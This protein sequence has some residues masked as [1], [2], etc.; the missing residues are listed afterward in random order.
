LLFLTVVAML[1]AGVVID[2]FAG[3]VEK[4][5]SH[6]LSECGRIVRRLADSSRSGAPSA[7]DIA[8]LKK[9]AEAIHADRL[10][11]AERHG[12][13]AE[14]SAT[15]GGTASDRQQAVSATLLKQL[16]DLLS[17]LDAIGVNVTPSD[18]EA[19]KQL[20]DTLVPHKSRPLLGALPYKHTNYPPREPA[21]S[22]VVKPAYKG[23]D[24]SV[25]AA[26]TATT[27]EAP[28][29]K[30]IVDLAQSLQWNP[31]LIYEWVKNN[32][33]TEWYWGSMKG[34][35]ETLR[36]KSGNDTDQ[37]ALLVALLRSANFPARYIKGTIEFFPDLDKAK[38]L[39]GLDDPTKIATF[40]Q[41]AG[42][43]FKP[44]IAGGKID[45]F[46]IEHIWVETY[47]SYSNSRG[48]ID[49]GM[50]KTWLGLDTSIKPPGYTRT[51][52]IA[53]PS[54]LIASFRDDYLASLQQLTPLDYIKQ[55]AGDYLTTNQ[56]GK[57]WSDLLDQQAII[58]NIL[59]IIPS[60]L[61]FPQIAITGEYQTL[62][63]E[64]K[65]KLTFSAT[66]GGNELFSITLETHKLSNKRLALRAEPE[67]VDDQNTIDSFGG[68]D[69]TPPYLVRLRPV[70]TVDGERMIV[71]QDGLPMGGD[72]TLSIDVITPNGTERITS[73]QINGNLSVI[74]VVAQLSTKSTNDTKIVADDDAETILHKEAI[75][76][77]GRWNKDEEDL[78]SL[79]GQRVS[80]PTVT[81]ATVGA[82]LEV[83]QL[84]DTPHDM[85]WKG[86]FLD[87]GYRRIETVGRNGNE[88]DFMRL[89]ALQGSILEN[90]IFEDDL[91]VDSVSTAKLLQLA[92]A[93]GTA[94]ISIDKTTIDAILP[95][96]TFDDAVKSDI[97]NAVNQGLAV[98]IPQTEVAYQNW[99]GI[100][101]IKEDPTTGES[102]W[103]LSGQVAGGMTAW[104][105]EQWDIATLKAISDAL[106]APFSGPPNRNPLDAAYLVKIPIT[107]QQ[108]GVVG[109]ILTSP[110]Q[111]KVTDRTGRQVESVPVTFRIKA[112]GGI[113]SNNVVG[114]TFSE[115]NTV[116]ATKTDMKGLA[117][118]PLILGQKTGGNPS[119]WYTD[120]NTYSNQYGTNIV[121]VALD[122][123]IAIDAPFSAYGAP[124]PLSLL[125]PT[126]G[127]TMQGFFLSYGGFVAL[128]AEDSYGNPIANQK[129]TFKLGQTNVTGS[130][131]TKTYDTTSAL[132]VKSGD[133]CLNTPLTISAAASCRNA[134]TTVI[135]TTSISGAW[136][137]VVLGGAPGATY[138]VTATAVVGNATFTAQYAPSTYDLVSCSENV[139][140]KAQLVISSLIPTDV[141]GNSINAA[142]S[143]SVISVIA[144]QYLIKEGD[145]TTA[146]NLSCDTG[147]L[148]CPKVVGNH[149]YGTTTD[150][151]D[152]SAKFDHLPANNLGNGLFQANYTLKPGLNTITI[153]GLASYGFKRRINSCANG[154][155][156]EATTEVRTL[157][158]ATAIQ[159]YGVDIAI[160]QPLNIMLNNQ[161]ISRNNLKISY[162]INPASYQAANALILLYKVTDQNGQKNYE[163]ID[164]ILVENKG[165]GF[166]TLARG[167]RFDDTQNY[168]IKVALNYGTYVQILSDPVPIN[169]GGA[170]VPDYNHNRK[171]DEEDLDRAANG[172]TYYFWV[173]DDDGNGDSEGSGIP[174]SGLGS[175]IDPAHLKIDGTRDL[176]DFFPVH[177]DL[178][179]MFKKY[180]PAT[181][182]YRLRNADSALNYVVTDLGPTESGEYLT[183]EKRGINF[184][185]TMGSAPTIS[186]T[187]T[188]FNI[189]T[190]QYLP[191]KPEVIEQI[192]QGKGVILIEGYKKTASS[193]V[194]EV[195]KGTTL[196]DSSLKLN[197]S[198]DGIEQMFRHKNLMHEMYFIQNPPEGYTPPAGILP[199]PNHPVPF[200]GKPDRL[201][202]ED[203]SNQNHFAGFDA[204]NDEKD[205]VHVHGYN[206][207]GQAARGEH[208]EVFKR[209]YWSGSN[210]K[211][212]GITWYGYDSQ[213]ALEYPCF[214]QRSPNYHVNVRHAFN[215]G[216]LLKNFVDSKL[217]GN[218]TFSAHSLGN[219]AV[220]TAIQ[221]G[222]P[223][224]RYIMANPAVAEEAYVLKSDYE[225]GTKWDAA[226]RPLMYNPDWRYF[227]G[228]ET[229]YKPFLWA[230]EWYKLFTVPDEREKLTWRDYFSK[231]REGNGTGKVF[232]FFTP[233]DQAFRPYPLPLADVDKDI[234]NYGNNRDQTSILWT[235]AKNLWAS[236]SDS[237]I[238]GTFSFA[239]SEL[240]KGTETTSLVLPNMDSK[241]GGWG[242]NEDTKD[243]YFKWNENTE[244]RIITPDDA[245][246]LDHDPAGNDPGRDILKSKP[247]FNKN[248]E[249]VSLFTNMPVDA[250]VLTTPMRESLLANEIPVL[251]FAVGHKG[252]E[253][254]ER[255]TNIDVREK[256]VR[257]PIA[258]WPRDNYEW[259]HSDIFN[260][261]YPYLYKMYDEWVNK[262]K[263]M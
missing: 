14:R 132:L 154:C 91:K 177:L 43:P 117:S 158:D 20:L 257:G 138:P 189:I 201:K 65:H 107:D 33:E 72:Y 73:G 97:T 34:A 59:K 256:Y 25:F 96:L 228:G 208:A 115:N 241:Y 173:N 179:N 146:E 1:L 216:K 51:N 23:G 26:D 50:G 135:D 227:G 250:T 226:T 231:V 62:P 99:T 204:D 127:M 131:K 156:V 130:C 80:R 223:Y 81:I 190:A 224:Y 233:T 56:P 36:Q 126:Y 12:A 106:R 175:A 212:W 210:A 44:V 63:D 219:M 180:D 242:F 35:E 238:L 4:A 6:D 102:G 259:R 230:S 122:N 61:Q 263:G 101:Y 133:D 103:M 93:N 2:A 160:K 141:Y 199:I 235:F 39:T 220:S 124:G 203:F 78:A 247:F 70:L 68:L 218:A 176:V 214:G 209:L 110:L 16:D 225:K 46:R 229:G 197:L 128:M 108:V 167:Y 123:G 245:N 84:L 90:R 94:N 8:L 237:A 17:R 129:V 57:Q 234:S 217:L 198:I 142:R 41:K 30:E 153:E 165:S 64:L 187:D 232:T 113:F 169:F 11:L 166:G 150:F 49:D 18:L 89:S 120:G 75:S 27:P 32:V 248:A 188:N 151:T 83:T 221:Q 48:A 31:V 42:I 183:G 7:A 85:Q 254:F 37:A 157:G 109:K 79:L 206:V 45:N 251:T 82:Q 15:L 191:L 186:I 155:A 172:D 66:A 152:S 170:L 147:T 118:V 207:N 55:K 67:T 19:L 200:E 137:G 13:L 211:F 149:T 174:E 28:I 74:G 163:Q 125:R 134:A 194:L 105:P 69:N 240:I 88:R 140:P 112:G 54:D 9:S 76:Y 22:P 119:Y 162:T 249:N 38:N 193:L 205:F 171:I 215:A 111:I 104:A 60:T 184:V 246:L 21:S 161:G 262:A 196:V 139:D 114:G 136:A 100:G 5:L 40:L 58:P 92:T 255:G 87:A 178:K 29:S 71:A 24:R 53:L 77:I 145:T 236:C 195:Y 243:G 3:D 258:P 181:Y 47:I 202:L 239:L 86:L 95:T 244:Y 148:S 121:D 143:G 252:V 159:V 98:T 10:L 52:G 192:K 116:Y 253:K 213:S 185:Q 168:A 260:V 261:G 182:T 144:K 222:M 164:Y